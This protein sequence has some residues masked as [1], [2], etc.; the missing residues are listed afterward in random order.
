MCPSEASTGRWSAEAKEFEREEIEPNC[1]HL[2]GDIA[3]IRE[4]EYRRSISAPPLALPGY[5]WFHKNVRAETAGFSR[6]EEARP[7]TLFVS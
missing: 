2:C 3:A 4:S 7:P 6:A 5:L 1:L